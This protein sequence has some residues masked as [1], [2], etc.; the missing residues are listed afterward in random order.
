MRSFQLPLFDIK[1]I[2]WTLVVNIQ[3]PLFQ[4]RYFHAKKTD[5]SNMFEVIRSAKSS[6]TCRFF[7][8]IKG[9]YLYPS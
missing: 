2:F 4:I 7:V 3:S 6:S 5:L 1:S 9:L 8:C